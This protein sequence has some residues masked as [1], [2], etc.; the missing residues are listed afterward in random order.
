MVIKLLLKPILV[1][2]DEPKFDHLNSIKDNA[3]IPTYESYIFKNITN[4]KKMLFIW[5]IRHTF[6]S[7]TDTI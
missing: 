5:Y 6:S 1:T 7:D 4:W 3:D 2:V